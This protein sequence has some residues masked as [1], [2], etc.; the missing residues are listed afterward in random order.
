MPQPAPASCGAARQYAQPAAIHRHL[1]MLH[2][3]MCTTHGALHP[4]A[5]IA[6]DGRLMCLQPATNGSSEHPERVH[7]GFEDLILGRTIFGT[8]LP[9]RDYLA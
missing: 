3:L 4:K 9:Q 2:T 7:V 5:A 6:L 1:Q 8:K